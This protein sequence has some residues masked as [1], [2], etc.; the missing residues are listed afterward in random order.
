MIPPTPN[1][2]DS[3]LELC[4]VDTQFTEMLELFRKTVP[5]LQPVDFFQ[6]NSKL[7]LFNPSLVSNMHMYA[8]LSF[9]YARFNSTNKRSG[10]S[11][12]GRLS[13]NKGSGPGI[14]FNRSHVTELCNLLLNGEGYSHINVTDHAVKKVWEA[15]AGKFRSCEDTQHFTFDRVALLPGVYTPVKDSSKSKSL[16]SG[17][18]TASNTIQKRPAAPLTDKTPLR[19]IKRSK[20]VREQVPSG[21]DVSGPSF[22]FN[23]KFVHRSTLFRQAS[24]IKSLKIQNKTIKSELTSKTAELMVSKHEFGKLHEAHSTLKSELDKQSVMHETICQSNKDLTEQLKN[25]KKEIDFL[26]NKLL[27]LEELQNDVNY[28]ES[29]VDDPNFEIESAIKKVNFDFD[30]D[31]DFPKIKVRYSFQKINPCIHLGI[32]LIR[33][34]GRVSLENTMPLFVALANSVFG[35][36]WDLGN[37]TPKSRLRHA[38]PPTKNSTEKP[39]RKPITENTLPAKSFTRSLEK[40]ILE[41]AALKSSAEAIKNCDVGSLIFDHLSIKRGKAI[42]VGVMTG[43]VNPQTKE[44]KSKHMTLAVKQVVDTTAPGTFRSV[45]EVLRLAAAAAADSNSAD[46]V[47]KSFKQLLSKLKFQVTDDASQMRPVCD[48]INE[49]IQLLGIDGSMIFIHCNAHIVPALDTGVTKVLTDVEKFLQISD[50]M[51]KSFNQGFHKVSNSTIHTMV[52]AIFQFIGDSKKNQAWAMTSDFQTFLDIIAEDGEKNFFKD[53]DSSKFGLCQEMCFILFYS[54]DSVKEFMERV[55]TGNNM[56]KSCSLY[57]QCPFFKECLLSITLLFY[58]VT[59]PFLVAVGAET[60]YGYS[61]LCHSELLKFFPAY[62]DCLQ[63][64]TEDPTPYLSPARLKYLEDFEK[65]TV[66]SKKKYREMFEI[67]FERINSTGCSINLEIVKTTLKLLSEEYLIVID[68]QAKEFYIGEDCV[69]AKELAKNP[70]IIDLV[71]TTSLSAEHSVGITRQDL[72]RAPCA[73][74]STL[75]AGQTFKSSPLG[76]EILNGEMTPGKLDLIMKETRKSGALKLKKELTAN[77]ADTLKSEKEAHFAKLEADRKKVIQKKLDIAAAVK[78]HGGPLQTP[79]E[80]DEMCK[81]YS[82]KTDALK[83]IIGLELSYQKLVICNNA[84]P[85]SR[86]RE[87]TLNKATG[88]MDKLPLEERIDNLKAIVE[89]FDQTSQFNVIDP[90]VFVQKATEKHNEMKKYPHRSSDYSVQV[91]DNK[92]S[93][94]DPFFSK[95][96]TQSFVAVHCIEEAE[97]WYPA[98]IIKV[99]SNKKCSDCT[100]LAVFHGDYPHCFMVQFMEKVANSADHFDLLS[101]KYHV[102]ASQIIPC[103]PKVLI[104]AGK[105]RR[106]KL[107]YIISNTEDILSALDRNI[108]YAF[109]KAAEKTT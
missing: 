58:H 36:N 106:S 56:Y 79:H 6:P 15:L 68:R 45:I 55:Y 10:S 30:A 109:R 87:K 74:M 35:Q 63:A 8:L 19:S 102:P 99:N 3:V 40:N 103:L 44:K 11:F 5:D 100:S 50:Q 108:L 51:V 60:Q 86:Y 65:I 46:D 42:T 71:A 66:I 14:Y 90:A 94:S 104:R 16:R 93:V 25:L 83:K 61:N 7:K 26:T 84:V 89:P 48:K 85:D 23:Y 4:D 54:F 13:K 52:R 38:L 69:V 105:G 37:Y 33:Q 49:L 64:L 75:S 2:F 88:K 82:Q 76:H 91:D 80:V 43:N 101:P 41:P 97:V 98:K 32:I 47:Q 12:I 77:D 92:L 62:V 17:S 9:H 31:K 70:E 28:V 18:V 96:H 59:A 34:I 107:K 95:L 27:L 72:R 57:V 53:P 67:I 81:K 21:G 20:L 29:K 1:S 78:N 22:K 24:R 73:L 39:A